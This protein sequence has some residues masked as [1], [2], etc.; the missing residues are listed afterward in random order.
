MSRSFKYPLYV[1]WLTNLYLHYNHSL[2]FWS[3]IFCYPLLSPPGC[4]IGILNWTCA[5]KMFNILW[6]SVPPTLFRISI[7]WAIFPPEFLKHYPFLLLHYPQYLICMQVL[8]ILPPNYATTLSTFFQIHPPPFVQPLPRLMQLL[9][10]LGLLL[11]LQLPPNL[12]SI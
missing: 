12:F 7:I 10:F 5:N 6:K 1:S 2:K 9:L 8:L 11:H 3:Y 4:L